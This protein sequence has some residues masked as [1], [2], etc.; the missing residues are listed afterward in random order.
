MNIVWALL[1][2]IPA[3]WGLG[4]ALAFVIYRGSAQA[5]IVTILGAWAVL[6]A[7]ILIPWTSSGRRLR[8]MQ[9]LAIV[10]VL[11]MMAASAF[12]G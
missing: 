5:P 11:A 8:V 2:M 12:A 6:L 10:G 9:V 7:I 3:G 1:L 4:V